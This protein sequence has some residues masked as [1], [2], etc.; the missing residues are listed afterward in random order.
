[1]YYMVL[2]TMFG[3][4]VLSTATFVEVVQTRNYG[5]LPGAIFVLTITILV[6]FL[7]PRLLDRINQGYLN[8]IMYHHI[9]PP[10]YWWTAYRSINMSH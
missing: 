7:E 6:C 3:T 10:D 4:I 9:A 2:L 5:L 1:M 8:S